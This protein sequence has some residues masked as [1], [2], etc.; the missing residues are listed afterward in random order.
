M[1][2]PH[3]LGERELALINLY[4]NCQL[5]LSPQNF[6][7]KWAVSYEQIGQICSRSPATVRRWF[8]KGRNYRAPTENDLRHL[9]LMD[10]LLEHYEKIPTELLNLLRLTQRRNQ[11]DNST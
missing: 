7:A 8:G 2:S 3:P 6:Y 11:Q 4:A 1:T 9:A 10:F 5:A